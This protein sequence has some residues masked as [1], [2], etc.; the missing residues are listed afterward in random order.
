MFFNDEWISGFDKGTSATRPCFF[1]IGWT[2]EILS[3][4][5]REPIPKTNMASALRKGLLTSLM[6]MI[7]NQNVYLWKGWIY[8]HQTLKP[9]PSLPADLRKKKRFALFLRFQNGEQR[10]ERRRCALHSGL[11]WSCKSWL[12][13][14][15][16]FS[17]LGR[18]DFFD[19]F[20]HTILFVKKEQLQQ[21]KSVPCD[22][23]TCELPSNRKTNGNQWNGIG[24][25]F[26]FYHPNTMPW[27]KHMQF[28]W[29]GNWFEFVS[30]GCF[31]DS[32]LL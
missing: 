31:N 16:I 15:P 12:S 25:R 29:S 17:I 13:L 10:T 24:S 19:I 2:G 26:S 4:Q 27:K 23:W 18:M 6:N 9:S 11:Q 3:N 5:C 1:L 14:H 32:P 8:P 30:T 7:H 21:T 28:F 20:A 22:L